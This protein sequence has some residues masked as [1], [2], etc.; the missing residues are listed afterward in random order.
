M[1]SYNSSFDASVYLNTLNND[2]HENLEKPIFPNYSK[3]W[4]CIIKYDIL[5]SS[6]FIEINK[7][8]IIHLGEALFG[9]APCII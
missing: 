1:M 5:Y 6:S 2:M 8:M 4:R 7:F 9:Y 3:F